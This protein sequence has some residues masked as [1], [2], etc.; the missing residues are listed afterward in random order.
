M[1]LD[2]TLFFF[3]NNFAGQ[4]TLGNYTIVFFAT[5]LPYIVVGV[6][7]LYLCFYAKLSW[8]GKAVAF[9]LALIAGLVARIGVGSTIRYFFPRP[10]PFLTYS[11]HQLIHVNAPSFPSGHSLFF[12]A[13]S[14]VVYSYNKRLGIVAYIATICICTARIMAGI[15]YPTD[16]FA[17]AAFGILCGYV[18]RVIADRYGAKLLA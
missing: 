12:F 15:H 9:T 7:A 18:V 6:F 5:Y 3:L 17:G 1:N 8:K 10:R 14:T 2:T 13:F 11:V 16:M 4:S